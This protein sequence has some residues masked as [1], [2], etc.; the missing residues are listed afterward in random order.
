MPAHLA[1]VRRNIDAVQQQHWKNGRGMTRELAHGPGWRIS[2]AE[3]GA[4][5]DFSLFPGCTRYSVVMA[6]EG[7]ELCCGTRRLEL[8]AGAVAVYDGALPWTATLRHG[9]AR[10]LNVMVQRD[11]VGADVWVLAAPTCVEV[12][13]GQLQLILPLDA[14]VTCQPA[15]EAGLELRAG[16]FLLCA[17]GASREFTLAG[18]SRARAVVARVSW[19]HQER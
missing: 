14:A 6:G 1:L 5:G 15:G 3:V 11:L 19:P 2:L 13:A 9:P 12:P 17:P 4:N 18:P 7:L 10:I 16:E 8:Q